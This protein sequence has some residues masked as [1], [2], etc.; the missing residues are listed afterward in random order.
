MVATTTGARSKPGPG[1]RRISLGGPSRSTP[2]RTSVGLQ[3]AASPNISI[4][5]SRLGRDH[6]Q[7]D[8]M[9]GPSSSQQSPFSAV[10]LRPRNEIRVRHARC[11]KPVTVV[12][13][14]RRTHGADRSNRVR[15]ED[16]CD[17]KSWRRRNYLAFQM[18]IAATGIGHR[19]MSHGRGSECRLLI[20]SLILNAIFTSGA[21]LPRPRAARC[22]RNDCEG[23][24]LRGRRRMTAL[25]S[26]PSSGLTAC[27]KVAANAVR[28]A[29]SPSDWIKFR[30]A[31]CRREFT[32]SYM[33]AMTERGYLATAHSIM[34]FSR[35]NELLS[36]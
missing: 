12:C 19:T 2:D 20:V 11:S 9:D 34:T 28:R 14:S 7:R 25:L 5:Q 27:R 13:G 30:D 3:Q 10:L 29:R 24:R 17:R 6:V 32:L 21:A 15:Q 4:C 35:R 33:T 23:W 36:T 18:R 31:E 8:I 26:Q 22:R 16:R 1:Q